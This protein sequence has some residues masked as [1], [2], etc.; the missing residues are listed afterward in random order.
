FIATLK[1]YLKK[2]YK[3]NDFHWVK[4]GKIHLTLQFLAQVAEADLAKL[5]QQ[6][7]AELRQLEPF[8]LH[9]G[10]PEWF[11]SSHQPQVISLGAEPHAA[12]AAL[13]LAIGR[14]IRASGYS[15]EDR[16]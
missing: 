10:A 9:L 12:L 1:P 2:K 7:H 4:P 6:V 8:N 5:L 16:P 15:S 3:R 11:P 14:G 13:S